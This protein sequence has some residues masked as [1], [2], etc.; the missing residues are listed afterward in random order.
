MAL[1]RKPLPRSCKGNVRM[2]QRQMQELVR[3]AQLFFIVSLFVAQNDV[4]LIMGNP[5]APT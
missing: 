5:R 4:F 2:T 3:N 1:I